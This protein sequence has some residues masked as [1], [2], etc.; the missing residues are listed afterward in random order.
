MN[1]KEFYCSIDL[2]RDIQSEFILP[3][4]KFIETISI[5]FRIFRFV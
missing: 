3:I 1:N 2:F 5:V 4:E